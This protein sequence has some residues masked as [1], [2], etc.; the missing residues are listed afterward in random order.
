MARRPTLFDYLSNP[1]AHPEVNVGRDR[2]GR[3]IEPA[4]VHPQVVRRRPVPRP[5]MLGPGEG[6]N[7]FPTPIPDPVQPL[8]HTPFSVAAGQAPGPGSD[9]S[10]FLAPQIGDLPRAEAQPFQPLPPELGGHKAFEPPSDPWQAS[11]TSMDSER[12]AV[13]DAYARARRNVALAPYL[14]PVNMA[15]NG[16]SDERL[17]APPQAMP[18]GAMQTWGRGGLFRLKQLMD[19]KQVAQTQQEQQT[20]ER[21]QSGRRFDPVTG[22]EI[23]PFTGQPI[24][25]LA[26]QQQLSEEERRRAEEQYQRE[27]RTRIEPRGQGVRITR[28]F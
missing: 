9:L 19:S 28:R 15:Q 22:W 10:V 1:D 14:G 12:D 26:F 11:R 17:M 4:P 25:P 24:A 13:S 23:D 6:M 5:R 18:G 2:S 21:D 16:A 27:Q 8:P 20:N 3:R 7:P